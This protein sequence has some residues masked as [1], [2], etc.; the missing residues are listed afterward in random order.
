MPNLEDLSE[1]KP[2]ALRRLARFMGLT[3]EKEMSDE[4]VRLWVKWELKPMKIGCY[5]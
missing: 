5:N 1:V 2:E 3:R 4:L